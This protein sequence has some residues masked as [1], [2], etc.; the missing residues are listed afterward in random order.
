[1]FLIHYYAE[2]ALLWV[3]KLEPESS[4]T[5]TFYLCAV[6]RRDGLGSEPLPPQLHSRGVLMR[7]LPPFSPRDDAALRQ[8]PLAPQVSTGSIWPP[9]LL[10]PHLHGCPI[11]LTV[12]HVE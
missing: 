2:W 6:S 9:G 10:S 4:L 1:M 7:T 3:S 5:G 8:L 12:S 11:S